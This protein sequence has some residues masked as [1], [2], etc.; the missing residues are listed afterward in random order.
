MRFLVAARQSQ[1]SLRSGAREWV[2]TGD[3]AVLA[4]WRRGAGEPVL[5]IFNLSDSVRPAGIAPEQ[6]MRDLLSRE[7]RVYPAGQAIAL[8]PYAALWLVGAGA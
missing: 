4:Y 5:C 6:D 1:P 2:E 3:V 8:A 7:G